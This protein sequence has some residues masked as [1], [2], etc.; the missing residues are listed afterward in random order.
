MDLKDAK[1]GLIKNVGVG[2]VA[3]HL[4]PAMFPNVA[5]DTEEST[6]TKPLP[7]GSKSCTL[8]VVIWK[9][10]EDIFDIV[11][12][13]SEYQLLSKS[14][15]FDGPTPATPFILSICGSWDEDSISEEIEE[16]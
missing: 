9:V 8:D 12:I 7:S 1:H 6:P 5:I 14:R 3:A 15:N 16:V 13:G 2:V 10:G 4:L 11:D